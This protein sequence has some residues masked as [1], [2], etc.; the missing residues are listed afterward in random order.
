[1]QEAHNCCSVQVSFEYSHFPWLSF[2]ILFFDGEKR[3]LDWM[4]KSPCGAS[5]VSC[6]SWAPGGFPCPA[7][8]PL[9]SRAFLSGSPLGLRSICLHLGPQWASSF[10]CLPA[11][12]QSFYLIFCVRLSLSRGVPALR[13]PFTVGSFPSLEVYPGTEPFSILLAPLFAKGRLWSFT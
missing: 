8:L 9:V 5:C 11:V 6:R 13:S 4:R 7:L 1:M 3:H 12:L 10:L 2:P